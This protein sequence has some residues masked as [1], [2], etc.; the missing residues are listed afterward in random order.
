MI[1]RS[2]L[3][4][5]VASALL[6][7]GC[8]VNETPP[9]T[10]DLSHRGTLL[11]RG[12]SIVDP[13]TGRASDP[14]DI[15]IGGEKIL[16]IAPA[17]TMLFEP[18]AA[19][20]DARGRYVIAGLIDVHA[21]IGDGGI[22][23]QTDADRARALAQFLRYGVTTIF[24]PGGGGGNDDHLAAWK[25]RC[26]PVTEPCPQLFGS[27]ALITAPGSHPISTIWEMPD[28]V[29]AA[30]LYARGAV[31]VEHVEEI[32]PLLDQ[33]QAAGLGAIKIVIEDWM[34]EVPRLSN[35]LIRHLVEAAHERDM[36][37]LAHIST[38]QHAGDAVRAGV[39]GLMHSAE[40]SIADELFAAMA[41]QGTYYVPTLALYDGFF[42]RAEGQTAPEPYAV[43]GASPR[44]LA[45]LESFGVSP[46]TAEQARETRL[47]LLD[48][49]RRAA[50]AGVP[51]AVGSDVNNPSVF[52]GYS[53]HEELELMV[54]AGLTPAQVLSAATLGGAAFLV[55]EHELGR[56]AAGS[57]ADLLILDHNP[58]EAIEHS[59]TIYAV[60]H[61]GQQVEG[62]ISASTQP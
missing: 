19:V 14:V 20:L 1:I 59:R 22:G 27:G 38:A 48:N 24:V 26:R 54:E 3:P 4:Y 31:T 13:A 28:D 7:V 61:R 60:I 41:A 21:H 12:V 36:R 56:I 23:V 45:S 11:V 40:D 37:V 50:A 51:L 5:V 8:Q 33:K 49:L 42:D 10:D 32:G 34:G 30:T 39:D 9:S 17:G 62:V 29:D 35:E 2:F 15:S 16:A 58:L 52:P 44:A 25:N 57:V 43:A 18:D 47:V 55:Q 53:T 46:F 6:A